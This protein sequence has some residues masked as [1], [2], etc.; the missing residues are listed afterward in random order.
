[1]IFRIRKI[2]EDE[3]SEASEHGGVDFIA[4]ILFES[5]YKIFL[6]LIEKSAMLHFEFWTHL[7]DDS[8]DLVRLA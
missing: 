8:P 7:M 2:I 6:Q 1:M 3:L 5:Q 4:A